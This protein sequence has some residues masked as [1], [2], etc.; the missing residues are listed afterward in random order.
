MAATENAEGREPD[1]TPTLPEAE[2]VPTLADGILREQARNR[3]LLGQYREIGPAG[4]FGA[5][6]IEDLLK[7]TERAVMEGDVV[8]MVRCYEELRESK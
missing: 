1:R 7:R 3:E 5:M 6:M 4:T 2:M 8:A